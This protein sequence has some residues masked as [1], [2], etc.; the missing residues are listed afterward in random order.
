MNA[1]D[2][3]DV[4]RAAEGVDVVIDMVMPWMVPHVM[5]GAFKAKAHY[6]NTVFDTPFWDL[7][8]RFADRKM[9]KPL[10]GKR[11]VRR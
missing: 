1:L 9:A 5:E 11:T 6:I 3:N 10:P 7:P 4:T 8:W 2:S